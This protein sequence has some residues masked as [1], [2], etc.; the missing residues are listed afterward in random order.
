MEMEASRPAQKGPAEPLSEAEMDTIRQTL[1][2][3]KGA[4]RVWDVLSQEKLT[5]RSSEDLR[6]LYYQ[7]GYGAAA[8]GSWRK[9]GESSKLGE[10]NYPGSKFMAVRKFNFACPI[11]YVA[12]VHLLLVDP[13]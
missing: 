1:K 11:C 12:G 9:T 5:D 6:S 8:S 3:L 10:Y 13:L 4:G 2:D 7:Q